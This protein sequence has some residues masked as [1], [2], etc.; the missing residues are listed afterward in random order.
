MQEFNENESLQ[1]ESINKYLENRG[2]NIFGQP[3]FRLVWSNEQFEIRT[4]EYTDYVEGIPIRTEVRTQRTEK[5]PY[6]WDRYILEQWYPPE[7]IYSPDRPESANGAYEPIFPF[8]DKDE[9][10]LP[11]RLDVCQIVVDCKLNR[12]VTAKDVECMNKARAEMKEEKNKQYFEDVLD[13]SDIQ[14]NLHFGEAII[15]PA[16]FETLPP[17]LRGK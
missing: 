2:K 8:E 15:V 6:L 5:Y 11:L 10:R 1:A 3:I 16:S 13:T 12:H 4:A 17:N 7:I 14:S 9:N